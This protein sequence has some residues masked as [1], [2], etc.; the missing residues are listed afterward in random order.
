M[1]EECFRRGWRGCLGVWGMCGVSEMA[2]VELRSRRV[3]APAR[4]HRWQLVAQ[5]LASAGGHQ[6]E[7]IPPRHQRHTLVHTSAQ[8]SAFYGIGVAR[9][10]CVTLV[11]GVFRVCR[12]LCVCVRHGSS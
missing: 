9:R 7:A 2:Q 6:H 5:A 10:G 11:K 8:L 1:F 3:S 12:V 4:E